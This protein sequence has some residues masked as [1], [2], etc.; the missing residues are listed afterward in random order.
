MR[1]L[2]REEGDRGLKVMLALWMGLH[3]GI[4]MEQTGNLPG[5]HQLADLS[6]LSHLIIGAHVNETFPHPIQQLLC[7]APQFLDTASC[8][9][10]AE[11]L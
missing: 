6:G 8:L 5:S 11:R 9:L 2:P 4:Q 10:G 1:E 3:R 7:F